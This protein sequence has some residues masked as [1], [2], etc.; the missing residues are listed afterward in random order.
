MNKKMKEIETLL[1]KYYDG[2]SSPEEELELVRYFEQ[3]ETADDWNSARE[4]LLGISAL[5]ELEIPSPPEMETE[6]LSALKNV[7][8]ER[9]TLSISRRGFFTAMSAAASIIILVSALIFLDRQ[10]DLGTFSD[11]EVA[12]S[13]TKEAFDLVSKY[14]GQGTQDLGELNRIETAVKPLES[15]EKV[16]QTRENLNKLGKFDEGMA[17]AKR[18]INK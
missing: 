12:Y 15:L 6:I 18:I 10:P 2:I 1:Q 9:K 4:Q 3:H 8:Q 7:Q 16:E 5:Q 11:P 14:F 17:Q 13:Q